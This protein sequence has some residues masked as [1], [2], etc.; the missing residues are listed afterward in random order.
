MVDE[1][2]G[3]EWFSHTPVLRQLQ[4]WCFVGAASC[5]F[6]RHLVLVGLARLAPAPSPMHLES[7]VA[8]HGH[9]IGQ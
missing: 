6:H 9:M 5:L 4:W 1:D 3:L 7:F 8:M 2:T